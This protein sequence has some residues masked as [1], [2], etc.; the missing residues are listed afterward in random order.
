MVN[1]KKVI[2]TGL[3]GLVGTALRK[4]FEERYELSS[5]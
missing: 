5:F 1:K 2:V 3:S 4:D